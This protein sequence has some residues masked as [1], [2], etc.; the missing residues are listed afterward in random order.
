[1]SLSR[2]RFL[3]GVTAGAAAVALAPA[4]RLP[5]A[6]LAAP[7]LAITAPNAGL[8]LVS[9]RASTAGGRALQALV[10][11][12]PVA[13]FVSTAPGDAT[14]SA[15]VRIKPGDVVTATAGELAMVRL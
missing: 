11:G 14:V 6:P 3:Q 5:I 13:S 2:R 10:N 15:L 9:A 1:M 4:L 12:K 7:P 8:Y